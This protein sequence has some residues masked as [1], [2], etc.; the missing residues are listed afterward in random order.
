MRDPGGRKGVRLPNLAAERKRKG[1]GEGRN[2]KIVSAGRGGLQGDDGVFLGL[3]AT[4]C[5]PGSY[6]KRQK[7]WEFRGKNMGVLKK[8]MGL[9]GQNCGT[10]WTEAWEITRASH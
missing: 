5:K 8:S 6:E 9:L 1:G 7:A 4:G 10:F 3:L 2:D